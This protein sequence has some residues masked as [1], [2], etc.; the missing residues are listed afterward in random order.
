M[1][2]TLEVRLEV[3]RVLEQPMGN[4]NPGQIAMRKSIAGVRRK[5]DL[6]KD[7]GAIL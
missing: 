6:H 2:R 1:A 4:G 3:E 5:T 7:G